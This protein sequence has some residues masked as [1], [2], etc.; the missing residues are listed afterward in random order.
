[1]LVARNMKINKMETCS[2]GIC[3]LDEKKMEK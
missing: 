3:T 1:M 2:L